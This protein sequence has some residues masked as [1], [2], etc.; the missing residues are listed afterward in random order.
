M[1][2]ITFWDESYIVSQSRTTIFKLRLLT[3][4]WWLRWKKGNNFLFFFFWTFSASLYRPMS[5]L[6]C[7]ITWYEPSSAWKT[8]VFHFICSQLSLLAVWKEGI[9]AN[10]IP[11]YHS[12]LSPLR[13][14]S[15]SLTYISL[16]FQMKSKNMGAARMEKLIC[17][18]L[19]VAWCPHVG[20]YCGN[21][22]ETS[23]HAMEENCQ[24][25][26]FYHRGGGQGRVLMHNGP[27]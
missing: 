18:R 19:H 20:D 10:A 26:S 7:R 4:Q 13:T 15:P 25:W 12:S 16:G 11:V 5:H 21:S 3:L 6:S 8:V 9:T 27:F 22:A 23:V 17:L 2:K 24:L 14:I 1:S